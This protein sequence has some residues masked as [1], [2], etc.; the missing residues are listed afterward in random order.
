MKMKRFGALCRIII[1]CLGLSLLCE[2]PTFVGPRT[3]GVALPAARRL[4][5][6]RGGRT[7]LGAQFGAQFLQDVHFGVNKSQ[8]YVKTSWN[9]HWGCSPIH[10]ARKKAGNPTVSLTTGF[11]PHGQFYMQ[12]DDIEYRK[13]WRINDEE[14]HKIPFEEDV[15]F[16]SFGP[17]GAVVVVLKNGACYFRNLTTILQ[18][19]ITRELGSNKRT[20]ASL[21]MGNHDAYFVLFEDGFWTYGNI[22]KEMAEYIK[23]HVEPNRPQERLEQVSF[24]QD[25][26]EWYLR[27]NRKWRY[28]SS[29]LRG[30]HDD[31]DK[32]TQSTS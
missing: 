24:T 2:T 27:T 23:E 7:A 9:T 8:Y 14:L 30:L 3:S 15:K 11:G 22:P 29:T 25:L 4:H 18:D 21:T 1:C 19:V 17:D 5:F 32:R 31:L 10:S 6:C 20:L 13:Y 28:R 26:E 12:F 16:V